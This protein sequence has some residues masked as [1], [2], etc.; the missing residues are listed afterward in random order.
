MT[1]TSLGDL[2]QSFMLRRQTGLTKADLDR[3]SQE[4]TT[5]IVADPARRLHGDLGALHA[6]DAGLSRLSAQQTIATE[7]ELWTGT[8]QSALRSIDRQAVALATDLLSAASGQ[9]TTSIDILAEKAKAAFLSAVA[10][11]NLSVGGRSLFA[12]VATDTAP[13]PDGNTMLAR[14][15]ADMTGLTTAEDIASAL[16]GWFGTGGTFETEIYGGGAPLAEIELMPGEPVRFGVTALSDGLRE[17]L[18]GL[19]LAALTRGG[20][21]SG[22]S[23][24]L[25]LMGMA[26]ETLLAAQTGRTGL[27]AGLSVAEERIADAQT[28][29]GSEKTALE[30][31]RTRLVAADPHEAA[32]RLL[33]AETRLQT[34]Y[35]ITARLSALSLTEYLR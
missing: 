7:M 5:G 19:A 27:A 12:G 21:L 24:R 30:L 14:I 22:D 26:G 1:V 34:I 20:P 2:A 32:T 25:A 28:R 4:M 13:L 35:T 16:D 18:K 8:M 31:A 9:Q 29:S 33:E 10:S 11:L 17:T 23:A 3:W 15:A 6:L